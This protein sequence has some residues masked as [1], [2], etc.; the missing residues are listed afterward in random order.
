MQAT[1]PGEFSKLGISMQQYLATVIN[2]LSLILPENKFWLFV[3]NVLLQLILFLNLKS[4]SSNKKE[5]MIALTKNPVIS[6]T[7]I[8]CGYIVLHYLLFPALWP[9]FFI[10]QYM[11]ASI[12]LLYTLTCLLKKPHC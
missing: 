2:N 12:G 5:K 1:H 8:C 7:I 9:R 11:I 3:V 4:D 6:L 10:G